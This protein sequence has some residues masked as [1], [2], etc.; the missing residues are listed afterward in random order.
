[1][2]AT[3]TSVHRA[4]SYP[5]G[6]EWLA[7]PKITPVLPDYV[8]F[9]RGIVT[10]AGILIGDGFVRFRYGCLSVFT[11]A[12]RRDKRTQHDATY[13]VD[14]TLGLSTTG[15]RLPLTGLR[16]YSVRQGL[17]LLD[18]D[19]KAITYLLLRIGEMLNG[20]AEVSD[21]DH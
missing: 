10:I 9:A 15:G 3:G 12:I 8:D 5:L 13:A 18:D 16:P 2:T 1:M 6:R 17:G 19:A 21:G 20:D 14:V 11:V 7:S 4:D